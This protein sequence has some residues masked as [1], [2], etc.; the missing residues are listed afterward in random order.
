M[1]WRTRWRG[2]RGS[3]SIEVAV[4]APAFLGLLVLAGVVGRTAVADEAIDSAAHDAARAASISRDHVTA[5]SA[6]E[7]AVQVR[8][9]LD[10]LTCESVPQVLVDGIVANQVTSLEEAF[11]TPLGTNVSIRVIVRCLVSYEDLT[12]VALN[13]DAGSLREATFVSPL[14]RYRSRSGS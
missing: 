2:D 11:N 14:D 6:A 10:G 3:V 8:L 4:L 13:L 7:T 12:M 1:S 9:N 5:R